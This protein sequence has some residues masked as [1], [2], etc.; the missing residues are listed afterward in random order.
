MYHVVVPGDHLGVVTDT[1]PAGL[2]SETCLQGSGRLS[3]GGFGVWA[4]THLE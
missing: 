1:Y 4:V 2:C 3:V